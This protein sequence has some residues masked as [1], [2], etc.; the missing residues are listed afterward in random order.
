MKRALSRL[1]ALAA[2]VAIISGIVLGVPSP[3]NAQNTCANAS[4][5][6][7]FSGVGAN[8]SFGSL[9]WTDSGGTCTYAPPGTP[10]TSIS[11]LG[12]YVGNCG[13]I[14][15]AGAQNAGLITS[16]RTHIGIALSTPYGN[17]SR[18]GL[19]TSHRAGTRA[20]TPCLETYTAAS[21]VTSWYSSN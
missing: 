15:V 11:G 1:S 9:G 13:L 5:S 8:I 17:V 4:T 10:R 6:W 20:V 7:T 14:I 21:G 18:L 19:L 2:A 12:P 3:V 16:S